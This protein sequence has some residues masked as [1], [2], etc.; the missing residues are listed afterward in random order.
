MPALKSLPLLWLSLS[1]ATGAGCLSAVDGIGKSQAA[2]RDLALG[3]RLEIWR[4]PTDARG[5]D[6]LLFLDPFRILV[7]EVEGGGV[8]SS[9]RHGRLKLID[10]RNGGAL[11]SAPRD[12][13][14]PR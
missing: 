5:A 10:A 1:I 12:A 4:S 8:Y 7:G 13:L 9:P 2:A 3:E 6:L 11:W 14:L